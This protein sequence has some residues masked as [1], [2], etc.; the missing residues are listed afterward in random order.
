MRFLHLSDLHLGRRLYD[1]SLL[2][3]QRFILEQILKLLDEKNADG[4][5]LAGDLYDKAVPAAEAVTLL[6]WFL[7]ELAGRD[8]PV[9]LVSGNHDSPER[10]AF[11]AHL[12]ESNRIHISPVF[13]GAVPP[14]E[15]ADSEGSVRVYLLP[16]LKPVH[17]RRVYPEAQIETYTDAVRTVLEHWDLDPNCRNVLVAHQLVTGAMRCESESL[18]IG[19]LDDVDAGVF[20]AFDYVALGHLHSPQFVGKDGRIRYCGTPLAYSFSEAGQ[21]KSVTWVDLGEKGQV[22]VTVQALSPLHPVR[23]LRGRFSE[24]MEEKSEDYLLVQLTDED[25]VPNALARLRTAY[26]NLLRME[27]DN[28]RTRAS[29]TLE[30]VREPTLSP[31]ELLEDFYRLRNDQPMGQ[32]QRYLA[33]ALMREIWEDEP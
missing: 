9:F 25:D 13:Q 1:L 24:L 22:D 12:L 5:L 4:V 10:L 6:D 30:P 7:T 28:R 8:L 2:E 16:F 20:A 29:R 27:Y 11:G 23:T 33:A 3:D 31:L 26:P 21:E 19:G 17:V 14:V 32:N 15:L 18:S